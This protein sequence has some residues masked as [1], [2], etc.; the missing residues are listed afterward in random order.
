MLNRKIY[1]KT[2]CKDLGGTYRDKKGVLGLTFS[3]CRSTS[4]VRELTSS[5]YEH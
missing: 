1:G 4:K 5:M 2:E 3:I